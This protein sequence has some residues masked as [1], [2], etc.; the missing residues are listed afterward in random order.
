L[1]AT[2]VPLAI[3]IGII[4]TI[5]LHLAKALER[6]GI[7]VFDQLRARIKKTS[8]QI[9]GDNKKP[10]IYTIGVV[11]NNTIFLY[12][13][14][15]QR[16]APP[17]IYTSM[18]G[19]GLIF[20]MIYA[21][22]VLGE[23]ITRALLLGSGAILIGTLIIGLENIVRKDVDR[24]DMDTTPTLILIGAFIIVGT[25]AMITTVKTSKSHL[26]AGVFGI[27]C[28]G[29]GS[30]D[31]FLK[32]M[33]QNVS[34]S[35]GWIP[36]SWQGWILFLPSFLIGFASFAF[37]QVAFAKKAPASVFVPI[38]NAS[39]IVLPVVLQLILL[40][41]YKLYW[42]TF[43]GMGLIIV[44]ITLMRNVIRSKERF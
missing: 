17:A 11:L 38:Y 8:Q 21:G 33:G 27:F 13:I 35:P 30:L 42:S 29:Y 3:L 10:I 9:D 43:S 5:Q 39:Y 15:A 37:T 41:T 22:K 34:G 19:V 20:L 7:E 6:Q 26:I 44:G 1:E 31:P 28:G 14:I 12:A 32:G 36:E 16:F 24:F 2:N 40:P 18:F 25:L 23:R 4:S